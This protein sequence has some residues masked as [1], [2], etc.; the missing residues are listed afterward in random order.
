MIANGCFGYYKKLLVL[1]LHSFHFLSFL[2]SFSAINKSAKSV[3]R[4]RFP[5]YENKDISLIKTCI[6]KIRGSCYKNSMV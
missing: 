2:F 4:F 1:S 5:Y 3:I 6:S